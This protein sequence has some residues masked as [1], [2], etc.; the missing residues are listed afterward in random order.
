MLEIN[1]RVSTLKYRK[2]VIMQLSGHAYT[3]VTLNYTSVTKHM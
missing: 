2:Q 3:Q 1:N